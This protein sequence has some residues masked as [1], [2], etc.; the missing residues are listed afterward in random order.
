MSYRELRNFCE[1]MRSLGYPRLI[2]MENFRVPNF[3]LVADI[4]Y[5]FVQRYDPHSDISDNI[6]EEKDRVEFIK[7]ISQL[8]ASKARIK[9][10]ASKL[11]EANGYAVRELLK[12]AT[13]LYKA[14]NASGTEAGA[15]DDEG[16][17]DFNLSSKIHNI[18]AARALASE[19]TES[20]GKL[21]DFLNKEGDLRQARGKALEFLDSI[22]RNLDSNTE[23][24]YIE[25]CIR[26]LI[27]TQNDTVT[28]MEQMVSNLKDHEKGL[29]DK[30]KKRS[31]ELERAEQRLK[32]IEN[33]RPAFMDEYEKLEK[34]L[35]RLYLI[36]VEKFRNLDYLENELD[37]YNQREEEKRLESERQLS[38]IKKKIKKDD[39]DALRGGDEIGDED[40]D[41][42]IGNMGETR[43]NFNKG[44]RSAFAG[45]VAGDFNGPA[46]DEDDGS[47]VE[48]SEEGDD[49]D[50]DEDDD[51]DLASEDGDGDD[52]DQE[53]GF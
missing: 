21:F 28:E 23:Q 53:D 38:L 4:L 34:D 3:E 40:V 22:S 45:R 13:M 10:N 5:W 31:A 39:M 17:V 15:L 33:V 37:L 29:E 52:N 43:T 46:E 51:V 19:I 47:E 27:Q 35:E 7:S 42:E 12:I 32:G 18:K 44:T 8:F 2:S 9:L 14:M 30:I 49:V 41:K 6:D 36:Y 1:I 16:S 26:E 50:N 24:D 11:Y 25:K 48:G 20:G